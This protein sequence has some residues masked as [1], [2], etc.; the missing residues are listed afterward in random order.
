MTLAAPENK[1]TDTFSLSKKFRVS[2][3]VSCL[4]CSGWIFGGWN[5]R[6]DTYNIGNTNNLY[7]GFYSAD[8]VSPKSLLIN[9]GT[10]ANIL[11]GFNLDFSS[12]SSIIA[13]TYGSGWFSSADVYWSVI[14]YSANANVWAG[15]ADA[16]GD[17]TTVSGTRITGS[18]SGNQYASIVNAVNSLMVT[19]TEGGAT[20]TSATSGTNTYG[21]SIVDNSA[22]S[23][24]GYAGKASPWNAFTQPV[25][26]PLATGGLDIQEWTKVGTSYTN[27]TTIGMVMQSGGII[28]IS[29]VSTSSV[30]SGPWL[31][32]GS[33]GSWGNSNN[34]QSN[35]IATNGRS[36][37]I[38]G[39]AGGT[40]TND[41]VTTLGSLTYSNGAGSFTLTG[42]NA[43][44]TLTIS[45]GITNNSAAT[46]T[47][48]LGLN[49][50]SNQTF[51]AASGNLTLGAIS[52][53]AALTMQESAGRAITVNGAISGA[54]SLIQS[55]SGTL[56]LNASNS[57][58][59]GTTLNGG[60]VVAG[61]S[62]SF[63][64]G[65]ISVASNAVIAAGA[66]GLSI[67]NT[68]NLT[69]GSTATIDSASNSMSISGAITGSGS[70]AKAGTGTLSISGNSPAF[71]GAT[72][73]NAGR[74]QV[75]G[76]LGTGT[77]TVGS[78][79]SLSG[80]GSVGGI[81]VSPGG[82]I[83]AGTD[84]SIG[85]LTITGNGIW[86][87]G[88]IYNWKISDANE[89][90]GV[91][92]DT[93]AI[94][95]ALN[96]SGVTSS[97]KFQ[98]NLWSL[99]GNAANFNKDAD[100]AWKIASFDSFSGNFSTN[101]FSV[102][103]GATNGSGGFLNAL[104]GSFSL[105]TSA[106]ALFLS[107]KTL[108]ATDTGGIWS[109]GSGNLSGITNGSL[110]QFTGSGGSVTNQSVTNVTGISYAVT[111]GGYTLS[112]TNLTLSGSVTNSS[113]AQQTIS[114]AVRLA[115][116]AVLQAQNGAILIGG[117]IDLSSNN[118][119]VSGARQS[120]LA[121]DIAGSGTLIKQG[122]GSL[123]LTGVSSNAGGLAV[124]S[125]RTIL[126]GG[127]DRLSSNGRLSVSS[128]AVVDLGTTSQR[129]EALSGSGTITGGSGSITLAPSNSI[130][131]AGTIEGQK[132]LIQKGAGTTTLTGSNSYTGGTLVNNGTLIASN[133][134]ALGSTNGSLN[135]AGGALNLG[136]FNQRVG[137]ATLT[138]GSI[139]N[140]TLTASSGVTVTG[141]SNSTI[142]A[143]L[144]GSGGLT[145][146]GSGTLSLASALP[147]GSVRITG[148][149]LQSSASVIGSAT[150]APAGVSVSSNA[151]WTNS[152][153][154]TVGGSGSG[155]LTVGSGGTVSA[156]GLLIASNATSRGTVT[157]GD[158]NGV[159]SLALGN[160][161]ITFG[162]G[163]GNLIF[164]QRGALTVSNSISSLTSGRGTIT[165]S[166][167]GTTTLTANNSR[168]S[169]TTSL[170]AGTLVLGAGSQ[171]GGGVNVANRNAFFALNTNSVLTST[172]AVHAV[173]GLLLDNSGMAFKDSIKGSVALSSTGVL[174]KTYATNQ[175]VAG[176][177]AGIGSGKS[178][179]IL[180]GT[181]SDNWV[182][183][184][185]TNN[186]SVTTNV[187]NAPVLQAKIVNGQLDFHGT[188]TNAIVMSM[189]DPSYSTIRNQIQWYNTNSGTWM[190]TTAGNT[191]NVTNAAISGMNG[192][193]FAGTFDSFLLSVNTNSAINWGNLEL[194][195][196]QNQGVVG[197]LLDELNLRGAGINTYLAKIMGAFGYDNATKTSWAVINHNSIFGDGLATFSNADLLNDPVAADISVFSPAS[198]SVTIQAVP[199]PSTWALLILGGLALGMV[200]R[201]CRQK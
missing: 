181:A 142:S 68:L 23:F 125:G 33:D 2:F 99:G 18:G 185:V 85:T 67:T 106:N 7:L 21:V 196:R 88:G 61:N 16:A 123:V 166:G 168:F 163:T 146:S 44:Q 191:G 52:N 154:L 134:F 193:S 138:S 165:S 148:G 4:L 60:T 186:S 42:T 40:I 19:A 6:A 129:F 72:A 91:G 113:T 176:F 47:I 25:I 139:G 140:G 105:T 49:T 53:T 41:T 200:L 115:T 159:G 37:G 46:Q 12:A 194:V 26:T 24:S 58:S 63:G 141:N 110:L 75:S 132:A 167:S 149:T 101:L 93:L 83:M 79:A 124:E 195:D 5:L 158:S 137:S 104:N 62:A 161:S 80:T 136:S 130:S 177:G 15:K 97:N 162:A 27:Q 78:G 51:N 169:G 144:A 153:Q 38:T 128:G 178:F 119:T 57:Y 92:Y 89:S 74:L 9:L 143:T 170:S 69:A 45:D 43:G 164:N 107:Y 73:V 189:K 122:T 94:G 180:A 201:V 103:L 55:G 184:R 190:N 76:N 1:R 151:V 192:R 145:K 188:T 34:W 8:S 114:S 96:L 133:A 11:S 182:T 183:N 28:S 30:Y 29:G 87:G 102:N 198:G 86:N 10:R 39:S 17:L 109:G 54:G 50:T 111:A 135:V 64:S 84:S 22:S 179:S 13:Q 120:T 31:W 71:S 157:L 56:N 131:Y 95:G 66:Q 100:G 197:S 48:F 65:G 174:Q 187:V 108:A 155:S 175:S 20:R 171:L 127:D 98:I 156:S 36:V 126:S 160:G 172:N 112:G 173:A 81:S 199:E 152:G 70:L 150:N 59:G 14:G 77:V 117:S 32:V 118:L 35:A 147:S 121:G 90:A 116:N 82:T 3:L